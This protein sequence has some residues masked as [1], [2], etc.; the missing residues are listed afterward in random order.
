MPEEISH[1]CG[2][3]VTHSLNDVYSILNEDLQHRGREG[4]GIAGI[5]DTIDVMKSEGT[6]NTFDLIDLYKIF[7]VDKNRY[8]TFIGH[9][10]Y[11]TRGRKDKI[12]E[13]AHPH[14]IGGKIWNKGNHVLIKNC[15]MA[16]VHNGQVDEKYFSGIDRSALRT[17]CDTE[18]LL[19]LFREKGEYEILKCIPGAYTMAVADKKRKDVI[20]MRDR[21]GIKPGALGWKDGKDL[22]ASEDIAFLKKEDRRKFIE[23]LRPG[24]VYYLSAD[25]GSRKE[26]VV[27]YKPAYCFFEWNYIA[28]QGSTL[29]GLSVSRVRTLLGERLAEEFHPDGVDFVT[30][31]PRC[32]EDAARSYADKRGIRFVDILYKRRGTRSFMGSTTEERRKSIDENLHILPLE[33]D[34]KGK[35]ILSVDDSV[36]RGNNTDKERRLFYEEAEP[37]KVYHA[38][39]TPPIGIIGKDGIPRGCMFGVDMPPYPPLGDE[40]VARTKR[41][42]EMPPDETFVER[43]R[44]LREISKEI[45]MEIF[46]L[47]KEGMLSVYEKL[48]IPRENLCTY[49]IGGKHPFQ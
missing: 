32:P 25:G 10:R 28:N 19:H 26:K 31:L 17:G 44:T 8:H 41:P 5:G 4:F 3:C 39:Y 1:N 23:E 38:S 9:V 36:V 42:E 21:T 12:L 40:F 35:T 11:A 30:Y 43:N 22:V 6:V 24:Y 13:D 2:L 34:L 27:D 33:D 47:S 48:G 29:N 37:K 16:I 45:G 49:C 7:P 46:Y 15:D 14:T 18:A 20:V